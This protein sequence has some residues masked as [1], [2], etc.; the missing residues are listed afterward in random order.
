[1]NF[2]NDVIIFFELLDRDS[3]DH[4]ENSRVITQFDA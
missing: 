4:F 3:V 2:E 1:M